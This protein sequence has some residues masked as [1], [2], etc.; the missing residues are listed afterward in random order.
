MTAKNYQECGKGGGEYQ[1]LTW[2]TSMWSVLG[3]L[4]PS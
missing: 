1:G 2:E 3:V 4:S